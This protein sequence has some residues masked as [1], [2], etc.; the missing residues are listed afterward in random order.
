M[1]KNCAFTIC[2][3][4]YLGYVTALQ[5]SIK[6]FSPHIDFFIVI[7]DEVDSDFLLPSNTFVAK[8]I[9]NNISAEKW[10]EQS[11]KYNLT[12]FCTC[13]KPSSFMYFFQKGYECVC[14]FD[15]DIYFFD[16]PHIIYNYFEKYMIIVTPHCVNM[17]IMDR[18]DSAEF[19][20]RLSG[21]FNFG[22]LGVKKTKKTE[23]FL[24]W[25]HNRLDDKCF[26]DSTNFLCTDQ[27]WGDLLP[28][29]FN[30]DELY[31]VRSM[32]WNL[33]PW[34]YFER[35][36]VCKNGLWY[37]KNRY[38][39]ELPERI[40]FAHYSGYDYKRM[41]DGEIIEKNDH[42]RKEYADIRPFEYYYTQVLC[43]IREVF[44]KYID[45][46]YSYN[47][48]SNGR[49]IEKIHRRLYHSSILQGI[50]VGNP[51]DCSNQVFYKKLCKLAMF[52]NAKADDILGVIDSNGT[53]KKLKL[54]NRAMRAI[55]KVIGIEK[56]LLILKL[57]QAYNWYENQYHFIDKNVNILYFRKRII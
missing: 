14:Y 15:P 31:I 48:F 8:N 46:Q 5:K 35:E 54:L 7:A 3:K 37:V 23:G 20:A 22:F 11:F 10:V 49:K 55:Y 26:F 33:A 39:N 32:G 9:L 2:T 28:C 1:S 42:H 53:A 27:K 18:E 21:I 56:Y 57:F 12:E 38:E 43:D 44:L 47:Y 6:K 45:L 40:L 41:L 29:Y 16:D 4:S 52:S 51:F 50:Y 36:V 19:D 13:I 17:E 30:S 24:D 34:N 25:W